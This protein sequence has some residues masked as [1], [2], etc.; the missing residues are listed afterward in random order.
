MFNSEKVCLTIFTVVGKD[1]SSV[2]IRCSSLLLVLAAFLGLGRA[3]VGAHILRSHLHISIDWA[4]FLGAQEAR[5]VLCQVFLL[6]MAH[7][8][9]HYESRA[10]LDGL[11]LYEAR[12]RL[13]V[14]FAVWIEFCW[15]WLYAGRHEWITVIFLHARGSVKFKRS[16]SGALSGRA[17]CSWDL[18]W[19]IDIR[20][21]W[22]FLWSSDMTR[23]WLRNSPWRWLQS[24]ALVFTICSY[25]RL[26]FFIYETILLW[27]VTGQ[28]CC[29][30]LVCSSATVLIN[31]W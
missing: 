14:T 11:G 27:L 31:W 28:T 21:R 22:F 17:H 24:I 23:E 6:A 3:S 9:S 1:L 7:L 2:R 25:G 5:V 12:V 13:I 29:N 20:L 4:L 10:Q 30:C 18:S 19:A 26:H 16:H 15:W 8:A